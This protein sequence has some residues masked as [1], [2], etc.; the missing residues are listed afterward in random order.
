M[1]YHFTLL[2]FAITALVSGCFES[3]GS[4]A[5]TVHSDTGGNSQNDDD[6]SNDNDDGTTGG[7]TGGSTGDE[8]TG[9]DTGGDEA[10]GILN[11]T[12]GVYVGLRRVPEDAASVAALVYEKATRDGD[13]VFFPA[14]SRIS[15][16]ELK[17]PIAVIGL[18][19][20]SN[21]TGDITL[22]TPV[23]AC[24]SDCMINDEIIDKSECREGCLIDVAGGIDFADLLD[25]DSA[26]I[27]PLEGTYD[28][29]YVNACWPK[30][31]IPGA[32]SSVFNTMGYSL[33]KA[34][35]A[36]TTDSD[37]TTYYTQAGDS[38]LTDNID[39]FGEA[40]IYYADGCLSYYALPA[41]LTLTTDMAVTLS[42]YFKLSGMAYLADGAQDLVEH[43]VGM[44]TGYPRVPTGSWGDD[45]PNGPAV[46]MN[47]LQVLTSINDAD[48]HIEDYRISFTGGDKTYTSILTLAFDSDDNYIGGYIRPDFGVN[49]PVPGDVYA[50]LYFYLNSSV[51]S[52]VSTGDDT[53]TVNLFWGELPLEDFQRADHTGSTNFAYYDGSPAFSYTVTRLV[54]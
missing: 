45:V 36:I 1:R 24:G 51:N 47:G 10:H 49:T 41:P 16:E 7:D 52:V 17:M 30:A 8:S 22:S 29:V 12:P 11:T 46:F 23:Y 14:N 27:P 34:S 42:L 50:Y 44:S 38:M 48:Q 43:L 18:A 40:Q 21:H 37:S 19:A 9:G 32:E 28:V 54:P 39:D 15:I 4:V 33:I 3:S 26:Q 20:L 6:S 35:G 53:Y 25:S 2:P 13:P 31:A 5:K